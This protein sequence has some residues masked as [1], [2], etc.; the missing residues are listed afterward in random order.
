MYRELFGKLAMVSYIYSCAEMSR[1]ETLGWLIN[2]QYTARCTCNGRV[3]V[4]F[5]YKSYF[6]HSKVYDS[7]TIV[8]YIIKYPSSNN[9][10]YLT[11]DLTKT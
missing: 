10:R 1:D 9:Y 7:K 3:I 6:S 11:G 5:H 2:T 4:N 8:L